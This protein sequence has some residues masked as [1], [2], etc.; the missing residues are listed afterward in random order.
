MNATMAPEVDVS[1]LRLWED[2]PPHELFA[3]LRRE[4]PVHLSPLGGF[5]TNGAS[6]R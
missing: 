5:G 1:D 4:R 6:G 2:G 3:R